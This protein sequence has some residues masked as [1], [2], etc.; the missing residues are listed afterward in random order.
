MDSIVRDW[1]FKQIIPAHFSA[2]IKAGPS[3][4]KRTFAFLDDLVDQEIFESPKEEGL[5]SFFKNP[6]AQVVSNNKGQISF[7]S[8]DMKTLSGLDDILV[9][10]GAVK[11]TEVKRD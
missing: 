3:D 11:K 8:E 6:F 7:N 5:F 9:S 1:K 4:F 2:P 10:L